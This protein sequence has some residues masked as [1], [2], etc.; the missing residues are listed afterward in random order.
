MLFQADFDEFGFREIADAKRHYREAF[1]AVME[2]DGRFAV[3]GNGRVF[4]P[5]RRRTPTGT[6]AER[7][8]AA[9]GTSEE[10]FRA[11]DG[12]TLSEIGRLLQGHSFDARRLRQLH[13]VGSLLIAVGVSA[14]FIAMS[15]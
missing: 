15:V 2:P 6:D 12:L 10:L 5:I 8:T 14:A 9:K 13:A 11:M 3:L 4:N 7:C 1:A